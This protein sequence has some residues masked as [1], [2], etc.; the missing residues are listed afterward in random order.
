MAPI[1]SYLVAIVGLASLGTCQD[2]DN[3]G[4][5]NGYTDFS[6]T[7]LVGRLVRNSQTLASLQPGSNTAFNFL[8]YDYL[9][10]R[11][12]NGAHHIGDVTFRYRTAGGSTWTSVDSASARRPV[13]SLTTL[14]AGVFAAANINPTLPTGLPLNVTREWLKLGQDI[15]LRVNL[16]NT[17]TSSIEIGSLGLPIYINNVFADRTADATR[18]GCS[19]ADPYIGLDAGYVRV[20]PVGGVGNAL[21]IT[22]LGNSSFEAWRFLTEPQGSLGYQQQTFEGTYEWQIHSLAWAQNEWRSATPWNTATSRT[23][24]PGQTYSV[25]IRLSVADSISTIEQ[26]VID[27]DTPVAV[28]IPG[29]VVPRDTSASL[30]LNYSS[31]V[32]SIDGGGAFTTTLIS[33]SN[34]RLTPSSSSWGRSKVTVRYANGKTQTVHYFITKAAPETIADLG[35]FLTT[36]QYYND[37]SDPFGRAPSVLTYDRDVNRFV[38]QD[39]RVWI[40]GL[41]DEA[42]AGAYLAATMKQ[43]IQPE[44]GEVARLDDF[45]HKT[46]W[47]DIQA[48][49]SYGV[50]ASIFFYEPGVVNYQY[51]SSF[52][53]TSWTSWNRARAYSTTRAYNFI[54]ATGAY[55]AMYRAARDYPAIR[56]QSTWDWYLN[57]AYETV[58]YCLGGNNACD[59]AD[60]GLMGETVTGELLKDLGRE[61][62]TAKHDNL[63]TIMRRRATT[64]NSQSDPFG[65]E[66]AWDSTGQEGVY[67]WTK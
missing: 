22:P 67:Y 5:G 60:V 8:A 45:V 37:T 27:T 54:H 4:L 31:P 6:T 48:N 7:D 42:G 34:Y 17:G 55:W 26:A 20:T 51:N 18:T 36:T 39:P 12:Y 13:T 15:G 62:M 25:G 29:Y 46:L 24:A 11:A 65:S 2:T 44:S 57:Q 30:F 14:G 63:E 19:L 56:T 16:T 10:K 40:A 33:G 47:G 61:N 53:W 59:Y 38:T 35:H 50:R 66:M 23:I 1:L 43:A 3:L 28:G 32:T 41:S 58:V 21:A 52:D 64:W 9:P 49:G